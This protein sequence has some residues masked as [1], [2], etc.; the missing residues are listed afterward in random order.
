MNDNDKQI[1][2]SFNLV[3]NVTEKEYFKNLY[4]LSNNYI[5]NYRIEQIKKKNGKKRTI[6]IP[7]LFLKEIQKKILHNILEKMDVSIYAKAYRKGFSLVDNTKG[8]VDN[9]LILKLDIYKFFDNI[10]FEDVYGIF[11]QK[12]SKS[13]S[14]LL[15]S[16]CTYTGFLPQGTPTAAYLSNLVLKDF[17]YLVG[18]WCCEH[19]IAYTRYSDDMTF[20]GDINVSEVVNFIKTCLK[21]Y[22]FRLNYDKICLVGKN[23]TQKVTGLVVN[24]KVNIDRKYRKRIRQE[25]YYIK[26]Y[27][28]REH[29]KFLGISNKD[30]YLN[31]L[32][33]RINFV[34]SIT[35]LQEFLAYREYI[36]KLKNEG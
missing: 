31:S 9:N 36:Y 11:Y 2:L 33:G 3:E 24:E 13:I 10:S 32:I 22:G 29:L 17:D 20:S 25:M 7:S 16:L 8:H 18:E 28:I 15:A 6:Y 27:G 12:Y 5:N 34:Y 4:A 30:R 23:Q 1:L 21:K 26:K 14:V 19:K 35:N